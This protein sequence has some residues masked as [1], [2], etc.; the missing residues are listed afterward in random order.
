MDAT[1]NRYNMSNGFETLINSKQYKE[2]IS[3]MSDE[4][5]AILEKNIKNI[6][7]QFEKNII[8]PLKSLETNS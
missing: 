8:E 4:E 2:L 3:K 7:E 6:F 1:H 5:K